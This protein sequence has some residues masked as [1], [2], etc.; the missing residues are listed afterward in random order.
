MGD[1]A[2]AKLL[3]DESSLGGK[4]LEM[5]EFILPAGTVS[6]R[7]EHGSVEILYVLS[8]V[9]D[10][11][12]NGE[13]HRLTAGMI[14]IVRPG[15]TVRHIVPKDANV[16]LLVIW[17]PGGEAQRVGII[18]PLRCANLQVAT[19]KGNGDVK[20]ASSYECKGP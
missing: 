7:H 6:E 9:L 8:G 5:A 10:H 16:K 3:L 20:A 15:D 13:A 14:G 2:R 4:E 18:P 19:Y 12:L 11:E 17:T 1:T